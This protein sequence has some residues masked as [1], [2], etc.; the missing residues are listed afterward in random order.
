MILDDNDIHE[1][2]RTRGKEACFWGFLSRIIVIDKMSIPL[3]LR[4]S[5]LFNKVQCVG[6]SLSRPET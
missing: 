1:T 5:N 2:Y 3:I 4:F 6:H